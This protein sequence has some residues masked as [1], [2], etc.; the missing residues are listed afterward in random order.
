VEAK[1]AKAEIVMWERTVFQAVSVF[2]AQRAVRGEKD[3]ASRGIMGGF[4]FVTMPGACYCISSP[5]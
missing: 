5:G 1:G 2:H 4:C 3:P